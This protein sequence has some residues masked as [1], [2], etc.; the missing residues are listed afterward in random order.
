M[1][2]PSPTDVDFEV[3]QGRGR[4]RWGKLARFCFTTGFFAFVAY[5]QHDAALSAVCVIAGAASPW[6]W[7][8]IDGL[9]DSLSEEE[10]RSL[11]Q[12]LMRSGASKSRRVAAPQAHE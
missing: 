5:S 12:R 6:I 11:R 2:K 10:V 3:I 1:P 9:G 8:F 4:I 7:R